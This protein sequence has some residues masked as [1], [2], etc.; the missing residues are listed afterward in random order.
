MIAQLDLWPL[1]V[2]RLPWGGR[3]P[4]SMT[5][6]ALDRVV[7]LKPQGA[8]DERVFNDPDQVDLWLPAKKAPWVYQG[9]PLLKE[10]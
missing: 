7:I 2:A 5:R 1:E 9:A 10:V 6:V 4:R 8:K 3:S